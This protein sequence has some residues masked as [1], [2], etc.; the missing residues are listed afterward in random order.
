MIGAFLPGSAMPATAPASDNAAQISIASAKPA[1]N[2]C[3]EPRWPVCAKAATATAMPITPPRKRSVLN[4]PEALPISLAVTAP[5][6]ALCAAGIAIE[7]P[8]PA[9]ISGATRWM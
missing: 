3:A 9:T 5:S 8:Q 7:T 1:L 2:A 4:A 6:T